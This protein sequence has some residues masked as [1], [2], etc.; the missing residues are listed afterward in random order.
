MTTT[1]RNS[2]LGLLVL[3]TALALCLLAGLPKEARAATTPAGF[4]DERVVAVGAPTALAFTPDGRMLVSSQGGQLRVYRGST[5]LKDPALDLGTRVCAESER[6]LLG[7]AVDPQFATNKHVYLYYTANRAGACV[8]RVSRFVLGD[9]NVIA[10][11][12]EKILVDG[13][14]SPAGNHNAGDVHFGK[15]GYLYAS[16]GDGGCDYAGNSGC[17]GANDAAQDPHA[18]QGKILRIDREGNP[19]PNGGGDRC[20]EPGGDGRTLVGRACAEVFATGLRNPFRFAM[21][22]DAAGTRFFINDVGQGAYEEIDEGFGDRPGANYGWNFCEGSHDNPNRAGAVSCGAPYTLPVHDYGRNVGS[23]ITGGAFVPD[24]VWPEEYDPDY[25]FGDFVSGKIFCLTPN[26]SGGY[27]RSDFVT[28]LGG[29][30]AVAMTFGPQGGT[31]ALYYTTYAGGGEVRRVSYSADPTASV[32]VQGEPYDATAPYE[33]T[34]DGSGSRGAGALKYLWDFGDGTAPVETDAPMVSHAFAD[35]VNRTVTL[36]VRDAS[37]KTSSPVSVEVYPG[38]D[39]PV[40]VIEAPGEAATFR[41]DE[42]ITASGGA[43]DPEDGTL[44]PERLKWEVI[45]H[46][47]APNAHTHPFKEGIGNSVDFVA[48]APEDLVG[49]GPGNHLEVR[50]TATDS[51]GLKRTVSRRIE[52]RRV[53][54]SLA[55]NPT[56]LVIGV[57]GA[58][59]SGPRTLTSWEGYDLSVT[60]PNQ[61]A[62]GRSYAFAGWSDGGAQSHTIRTGAAPAT[63]T[64]SFTDVTPNAPPN[65]AP[66]VI[67]RPAPAPGASTRDRTPTVSAIVR[68]SQTNLAKANV[69]LYVDG[70]RVTTFSYNRVSDKLTY[71]PGRALGVGRH[72]VRMVAND[73]SLSGERSW[74]FRITR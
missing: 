41:V 7:V 47:A 25:L 48:P 10:P 23:S 8:N 31:Q 13:M 60:A 6:G 62:A 44:P 18:L 55:T 57:N 5:L 20:G 67:V 12:G 11:A 61:G 64:A 36:R 3:T 49:T 4:T 54:V 65:Y 29:S 73:G 68:D 16:V 19:A 74:A 71:T 14:P 46:H 33:F 2:L 56:G 21:D 72:T 69:R 66:P 37:G 59:I 34:F 15:D 32:K 1:L 43:T 27:A 51:R 35:P 22:P 39:A 28:G 53:D 17:A 30:S 38:D 9:D 63:Y 24:G 26:G 58:S 42:A 52:P 70:R 45:R 50:L 40:P